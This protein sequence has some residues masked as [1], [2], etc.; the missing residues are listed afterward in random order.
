[1]PN[2]RNISMS[3]LLVA[4]A[5]LAVGCQSS[6]GF[7]W[8]EPD[9]GLMHSSV[10]QS[11]SLVMDAPSQQLASA[12]AGPGAFDPWYLGRNDDVPFVVYG[13]RVQVE[14]TTFTLTRDQQ[15]VRNGRAVDQF[16]QTTF[17]RR[18]QRTTR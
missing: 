14:E 11:R 10:G 13:E 2:A 8:D 12:A 1:M 3:A 17:R 7:A 4:T 5:L 15:T 18:V 6:P 16:N 9:H